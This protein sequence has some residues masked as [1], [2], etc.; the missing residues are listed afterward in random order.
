MDPSLIGY[1]LVY[2]MM[3]GLVNLTPIIRERRERQA[4][5]KLAERSV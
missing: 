5:G 4:M 3:F 2:G 1:H